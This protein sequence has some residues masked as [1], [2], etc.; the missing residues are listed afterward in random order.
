MKITKNLLVKIIKE[1]INLL[2]EGCGC[3]CNG[4]PGGCGSQSIEDDYQEA[5]GTEFLSKDEALKSVV[6][7]AMSTSCPMTREHLLLA[8]KDILV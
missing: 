1:E 3:G 6:A 5:S 7:I 4:T 2:N 8:V